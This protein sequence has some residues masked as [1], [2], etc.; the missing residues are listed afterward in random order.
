MITATMEGKIKVRKQFVEDYSWVIK[1]GNIFAIFPISFSS[2]NS[3]KESSE[4][5][6]TLELPWCSFK[7]IYRWGIIKFQNIYYLFSKPFKEY[8]THFFQPLRPHV[9]SSPWP[10]LTQEC[11]VSFEWTLIVY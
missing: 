4:E 7:G 3:S 11:H 9:T 10:S 5:F 6:Y 2:T 8:L 1:L